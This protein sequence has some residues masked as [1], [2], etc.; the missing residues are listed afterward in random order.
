MLC[1]ECQKNEATVLIT[2][3]AGDKNSTRHLCHDCMAKIK[4][5]F[6]SGNIQS[7]L[8]AILSA[9]TAPKADETMPACSRCG[10]T[11]SQFKQTGKLGCAQCYHDFQDQ[12]KPMLLRIH[13]RSQHSGRVPFTTLEEKNRIDVIS[14][15]RSQLDLAIEQEAFEDAAVLRDKLKEM[16]KEGDMQ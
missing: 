6:A 14:N 9:M 8:S 12:L 13:G 4:S 7:L 10:L 11:F 3:V 5:D 1:E 15:L 16:L 2:L